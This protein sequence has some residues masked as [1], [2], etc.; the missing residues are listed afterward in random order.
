LRVPQEMRA[1]DTVDADFGATEPGDV[2]LSHVRASA[3]EAVCL[4]MAAS[5]DFATLMSV[6]PWGR[7]AG[8]HHRFLREASASERRG[9]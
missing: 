6:V 4:L 3:I 5:F 8:M 7:F 9:L 1:R 2:F